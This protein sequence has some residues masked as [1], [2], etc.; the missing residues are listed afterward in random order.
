MKTKKSDISRK[1][2]HVLTAACV[3]F[4]LCGIV[5]G[6]VSAHDGS[7]AVTRA[8][9]TDST[10]LPTSG[11]YYLDT[12]VVVSDEQKV[13]GTLNLDLNGHVISRSPDIDPSVKFSLIN[14]PEGMTLNLSDSG[15]TPH[16]FA[17]VK[18]ETPWSLLS[19]EPVAGEGDIKYSFLSD[20][21][22]RDAYSA[23]SSGHK[24]YVKLLGGCITGGLAKDGGGIINY[25]TFS[26]SGGN[27]VGNNACRT[28]DSFGGGVS[29]EM[30]GF[31]SMSGGNIVGNSATASHSHGGGVSTLSRF[32]MTSGVIA[33]NYT[34]DGGGGVYLGEGVVFDMSGDALIT[35]N[36]ADPATKG[37]AGGI[38]CY[39][40]TLNLSGY[41]KVTRNIA[42]IDGG[43]LDNSILHMSDHASV[44][45]NYAFGDSP[46]SAGGVYC[47]M[48]LTFSGSPVIKDNFKYVDGKPVACDVYLLEL[49]D[50]KSY[51]TVTGKLE[52]GCEIHIAEPLTGQFGQSDG[53]YTIVASDAACFHPNS[54]ELHAVIKNGETGQ[55]LVWENGPAPKPHK[56]KSQGSSI[57]LTATPTPVPTVTPTVEPTATQM[58][59]PTSSPVK[60]T[61][62]AKSPV[63]FIGILTGLGAAAVALRFRK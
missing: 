23:V 47:S 36:V 2:S 34:P 29:N 50:N 44:T 28:G 60:P 41:A 30:T 1:L 20:F 7:D 12:D 32:I 8:A 33:G 57:L 9:W 24:V 62:T 19:E 13:D 26:M 27:I 15:S 42:D 55:I 59:M 35:D 52:P 22:I 43:V 61:E 4:L 45:D 11:D 16:W 40:G 37:E 21:N 51:L 54:G 48:T 14:V 38:Q 5:C 18:K 46:I 49:K 25:G 17:Y 56:S 53:K 10:K 6:A 3:L 58:P 63:P 31:F 39:G